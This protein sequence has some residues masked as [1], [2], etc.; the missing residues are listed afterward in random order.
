MDQV[1]EIIRLSAS[2]LVNHLACQRLTELNHEVAVG[3][4]VAPE[5]WDPTLDLLW[6][7]G[8]A[9]EQAYIQHLTDDGAQVTTVEGWGLET[10]AVSATMKAMKAGKEVIAQGALV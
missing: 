1:N 2:D 7:R 9:H 6:E 3:L 8:L 10:T 4:R 5:H